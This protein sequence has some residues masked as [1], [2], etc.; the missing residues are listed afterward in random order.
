MIE[1]IYHMC[2]HAYL[3]GDKKWAGVY[4]DLLKD[5]F[6]RAPSKKALTEDQYRTLR[7]IRNALRS[8]KISSGAWLTEMETPPEG[9]KEIEGDQ[10]LLVRRLHTEALPDIETALGQKL[11]LRNLEHPCPPYGRVDMLYMSEDTAYPVEVKC[12]DGSHDLIGQILKYALYMKLKL[13]YKLYSR[14]RPV[15][16]CAG[17]SPHVLRELKTNGV[18]TLL[19]TKSSGKIGV[20]SV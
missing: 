7:D 15:T 19:Y 14:V 18:K 2:H 13:I 17:Y 8:G 6:N 5:E 11:F 20:R 1:T 10:A 3:L 4:F 16:I 9:Q 12:G